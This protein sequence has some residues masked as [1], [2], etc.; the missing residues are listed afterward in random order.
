MKITLLRR[1]L[2]LHIHTIDL[3]FVSSISA[4]RK[5]KY[6]RLDQTDDGRKID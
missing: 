1:S 6:N 4:Y 3:P 5:N 2:Y